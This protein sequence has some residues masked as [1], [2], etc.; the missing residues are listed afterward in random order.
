[1][2]LFFLKALN[3]IYMLYASFFKEIFICLAAPGLSY[4]V[5]DLVPRT[6]IEPR[7]PLHSEHGILAPGPPGKSL[8]VI[9]FIYSFTYCLSPHVPRFK[10]LEGKDFCLRSLLCLHL[11]NM[12]TKTPNKCLIYADQLDE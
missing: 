6:G 10:L 5:W 12:V 11:L 1:M 7:Q 4:S 9:R 8:Y 3:T 2:A